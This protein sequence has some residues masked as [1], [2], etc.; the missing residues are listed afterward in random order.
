M[1][2]HIICVK[3]KSLPHHPQAV[4]KRT[5]WKWEEGPPTLEYLALLTDRE[6]KKKLKILLRLYHY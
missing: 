5:F 4:F 6:L 1:S 2:K 3:K